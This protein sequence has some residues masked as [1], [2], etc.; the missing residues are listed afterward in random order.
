VYSS[1]VTGLSSQLEAGSGELFMALGDSTIM[2]SPAGKRLSFFN[3]VA[4][5]GRTYGTMTYAST[6]NVSGCARCHPD[7]YA[8]HAYILGIVP[9]AGGG[10]GLPD[11]VS[12]KSCHYET[13]DGHD[14]GWQYLVDDP[15]G[16]AANN[17]TP[18]A[19]IASQY[20]YK[21]KLMNDVHMSHAMEFEYPQSMSNCVTCHA[22]KLDKILTDDNFQLATCKS[23]HPVT[24]TG[25]TRA[26]RAPALVSI[27]PASIHGSMDLY[28]GTV[29][30]NLCHSSGGGIGPV[31]SAIHKGYDDVVYASAPSSTT[32][33]STKYASSITT[34]VDAVAFDATKNQLT[35]NFSVVGA[36]SNAMI[37]PTVVVSLYGYDTKDFLVSGH[38][39]QPDGTS[40][41][42][43]TEGAMQRSNPTKSANSSRLA[44]TPGTAAAGVTA[45]VATADLTLWASKLT[46]G[47]VKRAEVAI[48]P[49]LGQNQSVAPQNDPTKANYNPYL[50]IKGVTRTIDLVGKVLLANDDPKAY[51]RNITDGAKCNACHDALGTTFH[52]PNYGS[53]GPLGCRVCHFSGAGA[54]HLEMQSRSLDSWIHAIHSF[55]QFDV[56]GIKFSDPVQT[57]YYDLGVEATFPKFTLLACQA[58]HNPGTYEVPDQQRSMPG[59]LSASATN[60]TWDRTIGTYQSYVT[61]PAARSCGACH[62]AKAINEDDAAKLASLYSHW[63]SF[64]TMLPD[65]GTGMDNVLANAIQTVFHLFQF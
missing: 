40:N 48:L 30:C 38:V 3:N 55:Q 14:A 50:A 44:I 16:Y 65:D 32:D 45:W 47:S 46:D 15:A 9:A 52:T 4:E 57:L 62:R 20:A 61:G 11:F 28:A 17:G 22:G 24:G 33:S 42:E 36:A 37:K 18:P 35:V 10:S 21:A 60:A 25:G 63:G 19:A 2:P 5:Y 6:A 8:K 12:C 29:Q 49:A 39:T 51:G 58:C 56:S 31:F 54:F 13:R 53:A 1:T 27:L 41:L 59:I 7:P 64:S 26:G 43:W 23:C 34:Q